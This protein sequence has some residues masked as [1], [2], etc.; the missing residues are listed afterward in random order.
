M[1]NINRR[2]ALKIT[3]LLTFGLI[4]TKL[5]ADII[6]EPIA[7]ADDYYIEEKYIQVFNQVREKLNLVQKNVGYGKFNILGFDEMLKV[8]RNNSNIGQ[9][10]FKEIEFLESIF[11]YDPSFHGFYGKRISNNITDE[12]NKSQVVKMPNTGHYLFKG[13][14]TKVFDDL[15][16]DIGNTIILTSGIRSIVK[17]SRLFLD[18]IASEKGNITVAAQT[19]APPAFTYH[20]VGDFDVGKKDF[21]SNNF[22]S[23]FALTEEFQK[24]R[25][26][27]Y[28]DIRY[29]NNNKDGVK[30]EP[31]HIKVV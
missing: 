17:Q 22:S 18:K 9:F 8:A 6:D 12:V 5:S 4:N 20:L 11:Y 19:L 15:K 30:Y 25:K 14:S 16:K 2:D 28:V 13:D 29:T 10:S 3:G 21:G 24:L 31:W 26:L 23:R 27:N 1:S 7:K